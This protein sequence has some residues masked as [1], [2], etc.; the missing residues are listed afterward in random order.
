MLHAN[1]KIA[2]TTLNVST[3]YWWKSSVIIL[4]TKRHQQT[5]T[6]RWR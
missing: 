2:R 1:S 6:F 3:H 5:A 4:I